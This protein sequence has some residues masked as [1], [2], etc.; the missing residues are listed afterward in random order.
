MNLPSS[1]K[2]LVTVI[3]DLKTAENAVLKLREAGYPHNQLELVAHHVADEAPEID[4][5]DVHETTESSVIDNASKWATLGVGSGVVAG[6][7]TGFPGMALGM[8]IMGGVTGAIMGGIAGVEHAV[9]DEAV[10]LPTIEEY[11]KLVKEG[12]FLIVLLG[13]EEEIKNGENIIKHLPH[14]QMHLHPV[15]GHDFHIHP[16]H[17]DH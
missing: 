14:I 11:E 8:A 16:Q 7:M 17:G 9:E 3:D 12:N 6:L 2:A 4:T 10:N 13:T 1:H 15:Q 5:P